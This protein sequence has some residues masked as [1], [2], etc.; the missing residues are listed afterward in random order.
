[1]VVILLKPGMKF[2]GHALRARGC[3]HHKSACTPQAQRCLSWLQKH[4]AHTTGKNASDKYYQHIDRLLNSHT[5]GV[6]L[7]PSTSL[8]RHDLSNESGHFRLKSE[9]LFQ[10]RNIVYLNAG[11]CY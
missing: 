6:S 3:I 11:N 5:F 2:L 10:I 1:M 7:T 9:Y 4:F 8:S